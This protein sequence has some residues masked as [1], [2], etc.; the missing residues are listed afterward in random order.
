MCIALQLIPVLQLPEVLFQTFLSVQSIHCLCATHAYQWTCV[1]D[2]RETS[3]T[4]KHAAVNI[5]NA[6]G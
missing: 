6:Y 4:N 2:S 3:S 1:P 5:S